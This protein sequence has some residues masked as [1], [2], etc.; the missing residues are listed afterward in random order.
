MRDRSDPGQADADQPVLERLLA[1]LRMQHPEAALTP[2]G[3]GVTWTDEDA[4]AV[5][6][7][8]SERDLADLVRS[9]GRS[10]RDDLWPGSSFEEAGLNLLLVDLD[11]VLDTRQ[12]TGPLTIDENGLVW[13]EARRASSILDGLDPDGGPYH[14]TA[15]D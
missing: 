9:S 2:A 5:T 1:K 8:V 6:L 4:G 13:P 14:W 12:V 11:E 7:I 3:D 10:V 15:G